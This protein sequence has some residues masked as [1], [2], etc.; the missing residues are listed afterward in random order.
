MGHFYTPLVLTSA[1]SLLLLSYW[2]KNFICQEV[3]YCN[4]KLFSTLFWKTS[5][6]NYIQCCIVKE[7]A[8]ALYRCQDS[9]GNRCGL[10]RKAIRWVY[11]VIVRPFITYKYV[12]WW[13]AL[14]RG[15]SNWGC[16]LR[17]SCHLREQELPAGCSWHFALPNTVWSV[18]QT[19]VCSVIN[20][21]EW[22]F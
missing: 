3:Q 8:N 1:I 6:E 14:D 10:W 22:G 2:T 18:Y 7:S 9:I 5:I 16:W 21:R 20:L 4:K 13:S 19:T 12:V 17:C 11:R 15:A